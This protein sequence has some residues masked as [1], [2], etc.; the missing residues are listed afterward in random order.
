MLIQHQ[1]L[2]QHLEKNLLPFYVLAG[3][4]CYSIE[5]ENHLLKQMFHKQHEA[6]RKLFHIMSDG[7]WQAIQDELYSYDL[8]SEKLIIDIRYEKKSMDAKGK[9][10]LLNFIE[11]PTEDKLLILR[12]PNIPAKQLQWLSA[13]PKVCVIS[14]YPPNAEKMKS[15]IMQQLKK[16]DYQFQI[17][18]VE[19]I[20]NHVQGN[21]L[22]C[23]QTIKKIIMMH[24]PGSI[25]DEDEIKVQLYDQSEYQVFEL[26]DVL[27]QGNQLTALKILNQLFQSNDDSYLVLWLLSRELRVL[28]Q[29]KFKIETG[30][31]FKTACDNLKIWRQKASN[32]QKAN[33]RLSTSLLEKLLH[34]ALEADIAI[35][36]SKTSHAKHLMTDIVIA[37]TKG[38]LL[39]QA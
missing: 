23:S 29:L 3:P 30:E 21:M 5:K 38:A 8:F 2:R 20:F 37:F 13:K 35:K 32:Y 4:D 31:S 6:E 9:K 11:N 18:I 1:D 19:L 14:A 26:T 7:D 39:C 24:P 34:M 15:W 17:K 12:C 22:A 16:Q 36:T 27:L 10:I 25:L 28:L 33:Q